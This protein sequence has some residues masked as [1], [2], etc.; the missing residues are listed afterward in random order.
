MVIKVLRVVAYNVLFTFAGLILIALAGEGYLRLTMPFLKTNA[1]PH[2]VQ[3]VGH[4]R[5]PNSEVR[6][7]N[8]LDFWTISRTNSLGFLDREPIN[9]QRA[10]ESCHIAMIGDSVVEAREVPIADK[11]HVRLEALAARHLP[12]L[13]ITTAAYGRNN[14]GQI[15]QLPYYDEFARH[16]SPKLIVLVFVHNDFVDNSPVLDAWRGRRLYPPLVTAQRGEDG[17]LTLRPPNPDYKSM[18]AVPQRYS[19]PRPW[20]ADSVDF[21]TSRSCF[22]FRL[23]KEMTLSFFP[24]GVERIERMT[25]RAKRYSRLPGYASLLDEWQLTGDTTVEM[26]YN[27]KTLSPIFEKDLAFTAFGLDQFV[28]RTECDGASL[29]IL[30]THGMRTRGHPIFDRL[31]A[32]AEARGIPVIDLYDYIRRQGADPETDPRWAH[33][34]HWNEQ[35]H[36]WAA[37][38]LLEY[39]KENPRVCTRPT[40]AGT[41]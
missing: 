14:T 11:F 4:L 15:N 8:G 26:I 35:G 2:F 37:E 30:T 24:D 32:M 7:T 12:H 20:Y 31:N 23:K 19:S 34:Y 38:A 41:P 17:T 6:Y 28:E 1:S 9:P 22:A 29:V 18:P 25:E 27:R 16:L 33:D 39:I 36:Q 40:D 10:A 13:D 21:I 5:S 3:G